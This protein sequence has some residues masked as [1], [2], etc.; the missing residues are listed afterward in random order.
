MN[1][2]TI[3]DATKRISHAVVNVLF[4]QK[5]RAV[6]IGHLVQ[7]LWGSGTFGAGWIRKDHAMNTIIITGATSGIGLAV[8]RAL[9][10]QKY[11]VIGIGHS[12][13]NCTKAR[14]QLQNE[15]PEGD[16]TYYWGDL[17]QQREVSRIAE[18]LAVHLENHC[19]SKLH[20]LINNAGGVR[21]WYATTQEGYEQQFALNHLAGFLLTHYMMPYL[22]NANGRIIM[23][24]SGSHKKMKIHWQDI[25]FQNRYHPLLVYKQSKLCNMLFA[26]SLNV[27]YSN[28]GINAY[29]V[30]PGLVKTDIGCKQTGGLVNFVWSLRKK[31][32]VS[33]QIPA[34]TY[35]Y[36]CDAVHPPDGLYYYLCKKAEYSKT[37]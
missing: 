24:G 9:L 4:K 25:M 31:Q 12:E 13:A 8:V 32:G 20:A 22:K 19:E 16:I 7:N 1:T 23:T 35:A 30:D 26:K 5:F 28:Q 27:R 10:E 17:M 14:T 36:I 18:S 3:T 34:K 33:P 21:S 29:V 15:F 6:G 2:V 37:G 11:R